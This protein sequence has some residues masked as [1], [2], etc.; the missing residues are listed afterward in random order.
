M[1][2]FGVRPY[3]FK[4]CDVESLFHS[5]VGDGVNDAPALACADVGIALKVQANIDAASDAASVILLRNRLS[6]VITSLEMCILCFGGRYLEPVH[7][8]LGHFLIAVTEKN[9]SKLSGYLV[10][11]HV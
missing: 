11:V 9:S 3:P 6:Q 5:Q 10:E 8:I 2:K 7:L 4:T 1:W